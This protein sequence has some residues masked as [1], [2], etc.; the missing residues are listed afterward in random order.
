M[1]CANCTPSIVVKVKWEENLDARGITASMKR[2][3]WNTEMC[4]YIIE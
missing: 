3:E 1:Y 4:E 2:Y